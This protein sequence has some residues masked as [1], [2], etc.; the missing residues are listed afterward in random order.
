M[1]DLAETGWREIV[2]QSPE[3]IVIC[4]ATAPDCPVV[5]AN[6][7]FLQLSGYPLSALL[8][9]NLRLLQGTDKDQEGRQRLREAIAGFRQNVDL[10]VLFCDN[11]SQT[12]DPEA[13]RGLGNFLNGTRTFVL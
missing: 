1:I 13:L 3:G 6:A 12:I 2:E 10:T 5:Y 9:R 11:V 4:D 7:A 8:G